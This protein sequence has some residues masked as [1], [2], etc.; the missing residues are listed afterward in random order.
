MKKVI[1]LIVI[2]MLFIS[3]GLLSAE[4][5]LEKTTAQTVSSVRDK[6]LNRAG[7]HSSL[8]GFTLE[9]AIDYALEAN[10]EYLAKEEELNIAKAQVTEAASSAWPHLN[11][12]GIYT[13]YEDHPSITYGDNTDGLVSISQT[14]FSGGKIY[15]TIR[16]SKSNLK[17]TE[18]NKEAL[19]QSVIFKVKKAFYQVLLNKEIVNI[20]KETL[21]LAEANL[22]TTRIR[23]QAGE[24][25][26]Y[27]VLRAEVEVA[28]IKPDLIKAE[29]NL[30]IAK[31]QFKLILGMDLSD[32]LEL[33]GDF[34]YHPCH[35]EKEVLLK[36]A[37]LNR[38]ELKEM[39]AFKEA[40]KAAVKASRAGYFPSLS[41]NCTNYYSEHVLS[42]EPRDKYDDYWIS[43]VSMDFPLFD[44]FLTKSKVK[45]S[46]A[47]LEGITIKEKELTET[48]KF[49]VE[50]ALFS[51]N[52]A[53]E[54]VESQSQNVA[55]AEKA[56][57]IMQIR[58]KHGKANQLDILDAQLALS[59]ARLNYVQGLY[60][61][62]IAKAA[63]AKATGE[64]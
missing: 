12:R 53:Q 31:N 7:G 20:Q 24:V 22:K 38:P 54:V 47:Q 62:I 5:P 61:H 37:L 23:Y 50:N 57:K 40:G 10:Y 1:Y 51:L 11:L 8:T 46:R 21:A 59:T 48:V 60:E 30:N 17:A 9:E 64:E 52:A 32:N 49:D 36:K 3:P 14:L 15:N 44:G 33:I 2:L 28:N 45:Q 34:N 55:R 18:E 35:E 29:N 43:Y 39:E 26:E 6:S 63:L 27:D 58:Y 4:A 25:S 16:Q 56:Y 13:D 19:R 42:S 41:L